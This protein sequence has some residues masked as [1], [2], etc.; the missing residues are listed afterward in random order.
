MT[1]K[2]NYFHVDQDNF[3]MSPDKSDQVKMSFEVIRRIQVLRVK[4]KLKDADSIL[5]EWLL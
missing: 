1:P 4:T 5:K 3:F 2:S